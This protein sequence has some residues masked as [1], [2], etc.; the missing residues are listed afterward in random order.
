MLFYVIGG[1]QQLVIACIR[2]TCSGRVTYILMLYGYV[3]VGVIA[4]MLIDVS[5]E[6]NVQVYY[7]GLNKIRRFQRSNIS[8]NRLILYTTFKLGNAIIVVYVI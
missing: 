8:Q 1:F 3:Y 6:T 2:S 5:S 4:T 7:N